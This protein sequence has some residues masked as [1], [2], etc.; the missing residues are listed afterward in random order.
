MN[1]KNK[2][3]KCSTKRKLKEKAINSKYNNSHE[4]NTNCMKST[5]INDAPMN[6]CMSQHI[7]DE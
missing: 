4:I 3:S 2:I 6:K 7:L 5:I 1:I